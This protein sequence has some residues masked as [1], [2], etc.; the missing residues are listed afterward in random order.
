MS[1]WSVDN[2]TLMTMADPPG[3]THLLLES[4]Q[5]DNLQTPLRGSARL[6]FTCLSVSAKFIALGSNTG[7]VYIFDRNTLKHLQ[8]VFPEVDPSAVNVVA[9]CPNEKLVAFSTL[10]GHV[11]V[12][13][14]NIDRRARPERL[15]LVTEHVRT[16]VTCIQWEHSG[17]KIYVADVTGKVSMSVVP[18]VKNLV[19][20]PVNVIMRLESSVIQMDWSDNK[21][22]VSTMTRAY[23]CDTIKQQYSPVGKKPREGE[24][25][26]CFYKLSKTS[27]PMMYC[28]RPSSRVW[29]VDYEGN[30]LS[31]HQFKHLLAIPPIKVIDMNETE[32]VTTPASEWAGQGINLPRL[33]MLGSQYLVSWR[34]NRVYILNPVKVKVILW[35]ELGTGI[36]DLCTVK[37]DM[38]LFLTSGEVRRI[39]MFSVSQVVSILQKKNVTLAADICCKFQEVLLQ[40][41]WRKHLSMERLQVLQQQIKGTDLEQVYNNFMVEIIKKES[42]DYSDDDGSSE[43]NRSRS[44]SSAS[45]QSYNR[46]MSTFRRESTE[47]DILNGVATVTDGDI[48]NTDVSTTNLPPDNESFVQKDE[49]QH[50][51]GAS[52]NCPSDT[53]IVQEQQNISEEIHIGK[54]QTRS[55]SQGS[56]EDML[57]K[58]VVKVGDKDEICDGNLDSTCDLDP[59][60]DLGIDIDR[61]RNG[62][63]SSE[64]KRVFLH[65]DNNHDDV[66]TPPTGDDIDG[67]VQVESHKIQQ[68]DED[69]APVVAKSPS[70]EASTSLGRGKT[71]RRVKTVDLGIPSKGN[72]NKL[73]QKDS[74]LKKAVSLDIYKDDIFAEETGDLITNPTQNVVESETTPLSDVKLS[75]SGSRSSHSVTTEGD[76]NPVLVSSSKP[77]NN[78][79]LSNGRKPDGMIKV[80]SES[81]IASSLMSA[82]SAPQ[83]NTGDRRHSTLN[84]SSEGKEA[85]FSNS[86]DS[87]QAEFSNSYERKH[88]DLTSSFDS[89]SLGSSPSQSPLSQSWEG[90]TGNSH[91]AGSSPKVS[92]SSM[93]DSLQSKFTVTKRKLLKTIKEKTS[94]SKSPSNDDLST[95]NVLSKSLSSE[96]LLTMDSVPNKGKLG[97]GSIV[98]NSSEQEEKPEL[99]PLVDLS[100]LM[101]KTE[102]TLK[103]LQDTDVVLNAVAVKDTLTS[104]VVEL[105]RTL[106]VLHTELYTDRLAKISTDST[107][108]GEV[109]HKSLDRK[110]LGVVKEEELQEEGKETLDP[111]SADRW[112]EC[113]SNTE[114]GGQTTGQ[115]LNSDTCFVDTSGQHEKVTDQIMQSPGK[116]CSEVCL[117]ELAYQVSDSIHCN[118][119]FNMPDDLFHNVADLALACFMAGCYGD[120]SVHSKPSTTKNCIDNNKDIPSDSL[121]TKDDMFMQQSR[122]ENSKVCDNGLLSNTPRQPTSFQDLGHS[123]DKDLSVRGQDSP[124]EDIFTFMQNYCFL[125]DFRRIQENIHTYQGNLFQF[126]C[127]YVR[128]LHEFYKNDTFFVKLMNKEVHYAVDILRTGNYS[129]EKVL[130]YV[131]KLFEENR[132]QALEVCHDSPHIQPL[133]VY[134]MC[135]YHSQSVSQCFSPFMYARVSDVMTTNRYSDSVYGHPLVRLK[136]LEM[137]LVEN[138]PATELT[139]KDNVPRPG[140]HLA[141]WNKTEFI[142]HVL[143]SAADDTERKEF[144]GLVQ[145]SGFWIG[146][147]RLLQQLQSRKEVL[148]TVILLGDIDLFGNKHNYMPQ[149]EQEWTFVVQTLHKQYQSRWSGVR[150]R[151]LLKGQQVGKGDVSKENCDDVVD[152][153]DNS[154]NFSLPKGNVSKDNCDDLSYLKNGGNV[155]KDNFENQDLEVSK[156]LTEFAADTR[157]GRSSGNIS[158]N[159]SSHRTTEHLFD[160]GN[161]LTCSHTD[162]DNVP[163]EGDYSSPSCISWDDFT[164]LMLCHLGPVATVTILQECD[165]PKGKMSSYFHQSAVVTMLLN[166]TKRNVTHNLLEKLDSYLWAKKPTTL[167]PELRYSVMQEKMAKGASLSTSQKEKDSLFTYLPEAA[168][169]CGRYQEDTESHWGISVK[170]TRSCMCCN[171]SLTEAVSHVEPGVLSFQCGHVFHRLCVPEKMCL[172]CGLPTLQQLACV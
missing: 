32:W 27:F 156:N 117:A 16:T 152:Q 77:L 136:W 125:L 71:K 22:L 33:K 6:K 149:T 44:S 70:M 68:N 169:P 2:K 26:G 162:R 34:N 12:M 137:L 53:E 105:N 65:A 116:P 90:P 23:W 98:E 84:G 14:M 148:A 99:K 17:G 127:T 41:K 37:S 138:K 56:D 145:S 82:H 166:R 25:G 24:Y 133:D 158:D 57:D 31:T 142:L 165:I 131:I 40:G 118:D 97:F 143:N 20:M 155:P 87:K 132:D 101:T 73:V 81:D 109:Q 112:T 130:S 39:Q 150:T 161:Q 92:L 167:M 139:L 28:A 15:K 111:Y 106:H 4:G 1:R 119:P 123:I 46:I 8:V 172:L 49:I 135:Q 54:P 66:A 83:K 115:S 122:E 159:R 67:I 64:I 88:A 11:V 13:E 102:T 144:L 60:C 100:E 157:N 47:E 21:L 7:N 129:A 72:K 89:S 30:V 52:N 110:S 140:S 164:S 5:L 29:E 75:S 121:R 42:A 170:M 171:L 146:Y 45:V 151:V 126:W 96:D 113:W 79:T 61:D 35:T 74:L 104:W 94:L 36:K 160:E 80:K 91:T 38:Y 154:V 128:C 58:H 168:L 69:L 51:N 76:L 120:V 108:L 103:A 85:E 86:Y 18:K 78:G 43:S 3:W 59:S 95:M 19:E 134:F 10:N 62:E 153:M 48:D 9:L 55:R 107:T 93:K 63:T 124:V 50:D 163:C 114:S 147:L 141:N